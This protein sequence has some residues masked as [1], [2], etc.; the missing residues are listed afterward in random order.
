MHRH[1][2]SRSMRTL[3]LPAPVSVVDSFPLKSHK[4]MNA[5]ESGPKQVCVTFVWLIMKKEIKLE[6]FHANMNIMPLV[7]IN[8]LKKLMACVRYAGAT[9]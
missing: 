5:S 1:H 8:V 4:K 3:S 9:L 6:F 7:L 2:L